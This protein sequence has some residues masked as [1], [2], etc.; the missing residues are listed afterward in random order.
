MHV[1][2]LTKSGPISVRV[3]MTDLRNWFLQEDGQSK[4]L[5]FCAKKLEVPVE[6]LLSLPRKH[7]VD[8]YGRSRSGHPVK[9]V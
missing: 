6:H 9:G 4:L 1:K 5:S 8:Y 2:V 3:S 7:L